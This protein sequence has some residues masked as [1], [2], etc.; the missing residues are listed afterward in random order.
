MNDTGLMLNGLVIGRKS[1]MGEEGSIHTYSKRLFMIGGRELFSLAGKKE[2]DARWGRCWRWRK[3][4]ARED[5]GMVAEH[6]YLAG[7]LDLKRLLDFAGLSEEEK[8]GRL[9][10]AAPNYM[11]VVD[12]P[13]SGRYFF[14]KNGHNSLQTPVYNSA[15]D[16]TENPPDGPDGHR[17]SRAPQNAGRAVCS[18]LHGDG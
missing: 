7:G 13:L 1:G 4:S 2:N 14:D 18:P 12:H 17:T 3:Y 8:C 9:V 5:H 11:A 16:Y 6:N 10:F 15:P